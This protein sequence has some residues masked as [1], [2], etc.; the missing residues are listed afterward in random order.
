MIAN[1]RE[2]FQKFNADK[3]GS[4]LTDKEW[5]RVLN[6]VSGRT[7]YESAKVLRDKYVLERDKGK[8]VIVRFFEKETLT[9]EF[10][11]EKILK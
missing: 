8:S 6:Y 4:P 9:Y 3:L 11:I 1:F 2:Q 5:E 7:V 10:D